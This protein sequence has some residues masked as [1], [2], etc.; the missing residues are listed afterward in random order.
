[1]HIGESVVASLKPERQSLVFDAQQME[2]RRVQIVNAHRL[3]D[4]VV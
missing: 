1:M 3:V 4:D 2:K